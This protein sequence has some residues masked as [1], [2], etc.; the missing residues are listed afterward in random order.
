MNP[1]RSAFF[2]AS[3][4][5]RSPSLVQKH[6]CGRTGRQWNSSLACAILKA[7]GIPPEY[8]WVV[9]YWSHNPAIAPQSKAYSKLIIRSVRFDPFRSEFISS[10]SSEKTTFTMARSKRPRTTL[11]IGICSRPMRT[12]DAHIK[13]TRWLAGSASRRGAGRAY[14]ES[15]LEIES[16]ACRVAS[17]ACSHLS[18]G[19]VVQSYPR[20]EGVDLTEFTSSAIQRIF[21]STVAAHDAAAS[22]ISEARARNFAKSKLSQPVELRIRRSA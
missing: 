17:S 5:R 22:L 12:R 10:A 20:P 18:R 13:R 19:K 15:C 1:G 7:R 9:H 21:D 16:N 8:A 6:G 11:R 4:M 3:I 2:E 14:G